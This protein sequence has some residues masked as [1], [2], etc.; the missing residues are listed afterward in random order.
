VIA[1]SSFTAFLVLVV[2]SAVQN[3]RR[4]YLHPAPA[5]FLTVATLAWWGA[6]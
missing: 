3:P 6:L 4:L 2:V 1:A 5:M